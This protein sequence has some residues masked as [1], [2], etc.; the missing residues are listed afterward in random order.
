MEKKKKETQDYVS[1][2]VRLALHLSQHMKRERSRCLI[3]SYSN[4]P[5]GKGKHQCP[6]FLIVK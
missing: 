4:F 3:S 6:S 2:K 5:I 1:W